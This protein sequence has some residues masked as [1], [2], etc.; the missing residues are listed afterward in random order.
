MPTFKYRLQPLLDQKIHLK[1]Q[2]QEMLVEKQRQLR[3]AYEKLDELRASE[4]ALVIKKNTARRNLLVSGDGQ[5]VAGVEVRRRCEHLQHVGLELDAAK[6]AIFSHQLFI[7]D[8][9]EQVK[10][11]Q[12][13]LAKCSR[14]VEILEKH[15]EKLE[16]R[17]YRELER[18]EA[19]ELDE[20]GNMLYTRR[21][22]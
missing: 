15:R 5:A 10:Q 11:A 12:Q 6:D 16:E 8:C 2:A 20:I 21:S 3:L 9:K 22:Q 18:K 17:F 7:D 1:E 4:Q 14:D 19:L 13:H